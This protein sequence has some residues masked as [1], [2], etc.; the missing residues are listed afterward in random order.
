MRLP[1]ALLVVLLLPGCTDDVDPIETASQDPQLPQGPILTSQ[2]YG[3][4]L[5]NV[6]TDHLYTGEQFQITVRGTGQV[7]Y[8]TDH[9]ELHIWR[10]SDADPA[11][12]QGTPCG[13]KD[14]DLPG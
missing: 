7:E 2:T 4:A 6:P 9:L 1:V 10:T 8:T 5:Q 13:K 11:S 3:L 14:A 12:N